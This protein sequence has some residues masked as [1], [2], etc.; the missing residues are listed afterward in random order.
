M[1]LMGLKPLLVEGQAGNIKITR[2]DDLA[3]AELYLK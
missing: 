1:E 2:K 3:L